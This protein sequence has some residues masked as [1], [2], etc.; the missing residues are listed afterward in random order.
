ME[1]FRNEGSFP[2]R[3]TEIQFL[4]R[5]K[6]RLFLVSRPR[7]LLSFLRFFSRQATAGLFAVDKGSE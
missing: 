1:E 5:S 4:D 3:P 2:L 7:A 6:N